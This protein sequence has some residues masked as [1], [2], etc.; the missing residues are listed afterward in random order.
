MIKRSL[1]TVAFATAVLVGT[2]SA[3]QT[4]EAGRQAFEGR[5]ASCHGSDGTGIGTSPSIVNPALSRAA[6][7]SALRDLIRDRHSRHRNAGVPDSRRRARHHRF[8]RRDVARA[9]GQ[10]SRARPGRRAW[11]RR[12]GATRSV[13]PHEGWTRHQRPCA[14]RDLVRP[15]RPRLGRPFPFDLE[16]P[17]CR[18]HVRCVA[19]PERQ[20]PAVGAGVPFAD[21]AKPKAGEWPSYNGLLSGNRHS[22]LKQITTANVS[23]PRA[24]VDVPH[25]WSGAAL[26]PGH[27]HRHRRSHVRDG[28]QRSLGPRRAHRSRGLALRPASYARALSMT[29]RRV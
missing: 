14:L 23:E 10:T 24:E 28:G 1:G 3:A 16:E 4:P 12:A 19:G 27:A 11:R 5:C 20:R 22:P 2:T 29:R 25:P 9:I 15:R 21:I 13:R 18:R 7:A 6:T 8:V 26:A 17:G